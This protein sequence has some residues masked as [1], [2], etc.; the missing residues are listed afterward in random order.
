M[1]V[2]LL[3]CSCE[4]S[5]HVLCEYMNV[6]CM[7]VYIP[8]E[9]RGMYYYEWWLAMGFF[10]WRHKLCSST[11]AAECSSPCQN[12]D[13]CTS[14]H[15]CTCDE[16]RTGVNCETGWYCDT[17]FRC[18]KLFV[19]TPVIQELPSFMC[20]GLEG[21]VEK[22]LEKEWTMTNVYKF[23]NYTAWEKWWSEKKNH[24]P[25][26]KFLAYTLTQSFSHA[27]HQCGHDSLSPIAVNM[28][29]GMLQFCDHL[30]TAP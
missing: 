25:A 30:E 9:G 23:A 26:P 20:I 6:W 4:W 24:D 11:C 21:S 12:G 18:L 16:G 2:F 28:V 19:S 27:S 29:M 7:Q 8:T 14:L 1:S 17:T 5:I 22:V 3:L 13:N 15:S 10:D